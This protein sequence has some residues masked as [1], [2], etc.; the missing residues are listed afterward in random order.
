MSSTRLLIGKNMDSPVLDLAI[1]G[2]G[3][4][5]LGIVCNAVASQI[6]SPFRFI[7]PRQ[8]PIKIE[9]S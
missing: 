5:G 7:L 1:I 2:G 4:N 3:S 6:I 8:S 9:V